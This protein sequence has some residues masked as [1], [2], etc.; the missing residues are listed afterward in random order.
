MNRGGNVDSY[1]R[2]IYIH[3]VGDET[4]LGSPDSQG[5]IH[6][7]GKDL[8]PLYDKLPPGSLAWIAER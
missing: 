5:C 3:G 1:R 6:L 7:A 8:M 4:K 2:F